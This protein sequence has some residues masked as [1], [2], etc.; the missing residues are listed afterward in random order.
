[1]NN[2]GTEYTK[3]R[4]IH[5][6]RRR[7]RRRSAVDESDANVQRNLRRA[8]LRRLT[9]SV[10]LHTSCSGHHGKEKTATELFKKRN[11]KHKKVLLWK[12]M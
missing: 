4:K 7:R 10:L 5:P 8:M 6:R 12:K 11:S 3:N 9:T 1:M 2:L